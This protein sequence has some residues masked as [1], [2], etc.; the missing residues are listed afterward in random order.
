[1]AANFRPNVRDDIGEAPGFEMLRVA[2][3]DELVG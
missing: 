1:M 3:Y 2:R